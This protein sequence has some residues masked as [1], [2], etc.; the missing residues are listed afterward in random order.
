M[1]GAGAGAAVRIGVDIGGT[2]TDIVLERGPERIT[3][4]VLTTPDAPEEGVR[5]ALAQAM[6]SNAVAP[7]DVALVIHGTTLATNALIERKGAR[8]ALVTTE[9]FRDSIEMGTESR[10]EQYDIDMEK[11]VPLVP[12][13]WRFP[14]PER[15]DASGKPILPLDEAAVEA[16]AER[17]AAEGIESAAIGL[18]HSYVNPT[19]ER[20]V[21][22]ILREALPDLAITLS[23][24]VAP[25]MREYERFSTACANAYVQPVMARYLRMLEAGLRDAG[26]AC[27]LYVMLSGGGVADIGTAIRFP[28]RLVESG[29]VGGAVFASHVARQCGLDRVLS[30]DMGGTTAKICLIDDAQPQTTRAF[31]VAR[32]HRF[33]KGSGL[34]LRVPVIE[35]VEIGAGGG[36]IAVVD[37]LGRIAVGPE[38]AGARPGPACYGQGGAEPTVTDADLA[39]GRIDPAEFSGGRIALDERA[40]TDALAAA[41]GAPLDLAPQMAALGVSEMVG[42][43]MAGAARVHAIEIGATLGE[44]TMIAFGGAAPLHAARLAEKLDM[45]RILIPAAAAVGSAIGFLRA[46]VAYEVVRSAYQV[47]SAF[48]AD[49]ANRVLGEMRAEAAAIVARGAPGAATR[50]MRAAYMRYLGQGHEVVVPLPNRTWKRADT[51]IVRSAFEAAYETLY[52]RIIPKLDLEIV[53]WSVQV[54]A[55]PEA[56]ARV[57]P[58][59][60]AAAPAARG[61]R[62]VLD[63]GSGRTVEA[64]LYRRAEFPAGARVD[65]PALIVESDTT[66]V[67]SAAFSAS[68]DALGAIVMERRPAQEGDA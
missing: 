66:T 50:E 35:M 34:P 11:P 5:Q 54:T 18:L 20:R 23:A 21:R 44:R 29:P 32:A 14:V 47:V 27:P 36:S 7:E 55:V 64:A 60:A 15:L 8:T 28:I 57:D 45:D 56:V 40:A 6:E 53:S 43:N 51:G 58:P 63:P 37:R 12:R 24:E 26:F 10:F 52:G 22:E 48:D 1:A 59:P 67:V 61:V 31:E 17:L 39:M 46:P 19:H 9:G 13:R 16:I 41:V 25:E 49:A 42:E 68:V 3:A 33:L 4:K 62:P 2:F 65:G 38:S 30:F